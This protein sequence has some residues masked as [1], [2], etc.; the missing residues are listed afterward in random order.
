MP[1]LL[2]PIDAI[3][4]Q[5]RRDVLMVSFTSNSFQDIWGREL[6]LEQDRL[7]RQI[8]Q[9]LDTERIPYE[10]CFGFWV[11]GLIITP[12]QGHLYLDM[13]HEPDCKLYQ[14]VAAHLENADGTP[15]IPG[16]T[17]WLVPM[18]AAMENAHHDTE[19]YEE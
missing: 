4:R 15:R 14:R 13:P 6:N 10:K 16:V 2:Y 11:D 18:S 12:Y 9:W 17:F 19:E 5:R 3:A 8:M 1:E 7:R